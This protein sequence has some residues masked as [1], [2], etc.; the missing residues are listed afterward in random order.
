MK[1]IPMYRASGRPV[2]PDHHQAF[3]AELNKSMD[4]LEATMGKPTPDTVKEFSEELNKIHEGLADKYPCRIEVDFPDSVEEIELLCEKYG[5]VS[6]CL[7]ENSLVLY[8]LDA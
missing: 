5:A 6:F 7:E 4:G 1:K 8:V 2:E 3:L